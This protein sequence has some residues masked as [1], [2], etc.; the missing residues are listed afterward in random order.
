M[1]CHNVKW[2]MLLLA[3]EELAAQLVD[4]LP[5]LL[6]NLIFSHWMEKVPSVSQTVGAEGA[7]FRKFEV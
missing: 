3:V 7:Q 4:D 6:F 1:P 5:R 2:R